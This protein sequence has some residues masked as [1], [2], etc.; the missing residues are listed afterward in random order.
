MEAHVK[1]I[2]VRCKGT[3][4]FPPE[5]LIFLVTSGNDSA[6]FNATGAADLDL[7]R[8]SL[9]EAGFNPGNGP[10]RVLDWGCGCG[11]IARHWEDGIGQIELFGCDINPALIEWCKKNI[12][13]A[14]FSVC[15]VLPPLSYPD[16]HFDVIYGISV[17]THL[18][19]EA[20]FLWMQEI[21]RLLKPGG[22][23]ILTAHGPSMLPVILN[24]VRRAGS[25]DKSAVRVSLIDEEIF[26]CIERE[27]G[28]N[29]TGN[30]LTPGMLR[31]IFHPFEV[32]YTEPRNGLMGI[33]DTIVFSKNTESQLRCVPTL[34]DCEMTGDDFVAEVHLN[35]A[36]ERHLGVLASARKLFFPATIQLS[37][38]R[39]SDSS[40]LAESL[41]VTLP[42]KVDW[43]QLDAAH[44]LVIIHDIPE[45]VEPSILTV[46]VNATRRER[47]TFN[48]LLPIGSAWPPGIGPLDRAKLRLAKATLF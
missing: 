45:C 15:N 33:Q 38:R 34:L 36:R 10:Y 39:A 29:A 6:I 8:R 47:A 35:L 2:S 1:K 12:P 13:F 3:L 37:I 48:A 30:V 20:H 9:A 26:A 42:D 43:T 41:R 27:D 18:S 5:E 32:I 44:S 4:P 28:S 31:K 22:V 7:I 24:S 16:R 46:E 25:D 11:R 17:L 23:A 19:F 40:I 14:D 21:W